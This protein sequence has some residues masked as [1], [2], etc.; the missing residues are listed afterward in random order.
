MGKF[1]IGRHIGISAGFLEVP[2]IA[3]EIGC[4]IMQIF[5]SNPQRIYTIPRKYTELEQFTVNCKKNKIK[6][7]VHGSY[8]I[9]LC[10]PKK[11]KLYKSSVKSLIRELEMVSILGK[12]CLGV[13]IHMGKN[14]PTNKISDSNALKNY[15]SSIQKVLKK[16]PENTTLILETGASQGSEVG[17]RIDGL[18]E[19]YHSL[20]MIEQKRVMFCIDTCHIWSTGYDISTR[21]GA[22][23][24]FR[25]FRDKIGLKKIACIHFNSSQNDLGAHVDRHADLSSGRIP[26]I[27]LKTIAQIAAKHKIPLIMETPLNTIDPKT[28]DEISFENELKL[29]QKWIN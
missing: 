9:N 29:V 12:R 14:V 22:I 23:A 18:A 19:I 13:I 24:F 6:V 2:S 11:N 17:S 26:Q 1:R 21:K 27:G 25:E 5:L 3:A 16:S 7:V 15:I 10:H 28:N 20:T 8:T 4:S